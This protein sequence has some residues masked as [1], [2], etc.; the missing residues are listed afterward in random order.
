MEEK[1]PFYKWDVFETKHFIFGQDWCVPIPA[2]FIVEPKRK[3]MKSILDMTLEEY[4]DFCEIILKGRKLMKEALKISEVDLFQEE[5]G[6]HFHVWV[7]PRYEW[8]TEFGESIESIRPIMKYAE[9][10]M[11]TKKDIEKVK[12]ALNK[13]KEYAVDKKWKK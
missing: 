7:F 6:K 12:E 13:S 5:K 1:Y 9:E 4:A 11:M 2:F 3:T 10:K 8:M